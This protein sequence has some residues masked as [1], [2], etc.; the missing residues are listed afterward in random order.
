MPRSVP[1][2]DITVVVAGVA[3]VPRMHQDGVEAVHDG[4]AGALRHVGPD[5]Q[6]L[7]VAHVLGNLPST[8]VSEPLERDGQHVGRPV[9]RE[10]LGC[11]HLLLTPYGGG[12]R[13]NVN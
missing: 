6:E 1:Y 3:A 5:I 10:P 7:G 2:L 12:G 4:V 8:E 11:R 9:D 13:A